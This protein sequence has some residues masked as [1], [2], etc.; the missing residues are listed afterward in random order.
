MEIDAGEYFDCAIW[1]T[2][3]VMIRGSGPDTIITDRVCGDKALFVVSGDGV[4]ISD[5]T[6][7]R[8]RAADENG[9]GIRLE[10]GTLVIER[11]RFVNDEAGILAGD[12]SAAKITVRDSE[13]T[14]D[15]KCS[16]GHCVAALNVG[17]VSLLSVAGSR[18]DGTRGADF[19]ASSAALTTI[20]H[21]VLSDGT[22][23][24]S[25]YL[26]EI[27]EGGSLVMT[28]NRLEK[29]AHTSS[30]RGAVFLG[31]P[32]GRTPGALHL[33]DNDYQ[34]D[35]GEA[36]VFLLNWSGGEASFGANR[37]SGAPVTETSARGAWLHG[38]ADYARRAKEFLRHTAG[39][40]WHAI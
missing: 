20:D 18:F 14:G 25:S 24:S 31:M 11:V 10:G 9:A 33:A 7:Q 2:P 26:V 5:L 27:R 35:T 3:D 28:G 1:K 8:A 23:G 16:A 15:G 22:D 34:N 32:H 17:A 12:L 19:I 29:G 30:R 36:G 40:V 38:L 37:F 39:T 6:L 21:S 4:T 13:F